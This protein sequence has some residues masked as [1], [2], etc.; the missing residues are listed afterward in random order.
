MINNQL[1]VLMINVKTDYTITDYN[2]EQIQL[3]FQLTLIVNYNVS[4]RFTNF[5]LA[6]IVTQFTIRLINN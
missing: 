3:T 6:L 5:S 4:I 2:D 1:I